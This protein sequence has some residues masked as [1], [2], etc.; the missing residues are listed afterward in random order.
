M[1][2]YDLA[3]KK[4][5]QMLEVRAISWPDCTKHMAAVLRL[6]HIVRWCM[7]GTGK[8]G[9]FRFSKNCQQTWLGNPQLAKVFGKSMVD[10]QVPCLMTPQ[11]TPFWKPQKRNHRTGNVAFNLSALSQLTLEPWTF[12]RDTLTIYHDYNCSFRQVM[13]LLAKGPGVQG[14]N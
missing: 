2:R 4:R 3:K 8:K 13:T 10:C 5:P 14:H 1:T 6:Q 7:P 12:R 11:A 9:G